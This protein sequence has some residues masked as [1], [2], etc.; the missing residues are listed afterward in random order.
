MVDSDR[1]DRAQAAPSVLDPVLRGGFS[2]H[3]IVPIDKEQACA[4]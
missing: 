1:S 4:G 2:K 3:R